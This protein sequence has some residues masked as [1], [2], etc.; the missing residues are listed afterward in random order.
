MNLDHLQPEPEKRPAVEPGGARPM[1]SVLRV[2][3]EQLIDQLDPLAG[4]EESGLRAARRLCGRWL[5]LRRAARRLLP[6]MLAQRTGIS[7]AA[8]SLLE[9]GLLEREAVAEEAWVRLCLVLEAP[10][11]DLA[12]V[13][14]AV[15]VASGLLTEP[16][17]ALLLQLEAELVIPQELAPAPAVEPGLVRAT[18]NTAVVQQRILSEEGRGILEALAGAESL[19]LTGYGILRWLEQHYRIYINPAVLPL[20]LDA[21]IRE[22]LLLRG[23]GEPYVYTITS[24]G[25]NLLDLELEGIET[26]QKQQDLA[27]K[28]LALKRQRPSLFGV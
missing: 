13:E 26:Q 28:V 15:A 24:E 17:P 7:E 10:M 16:D 19:T 9:L 27:S 21:M 6:A 14:Q 3:I 2:A 8:L 4:A 22:G 23:A 25:R 1:D 5:M 12:R 11:N 18:P 20:K